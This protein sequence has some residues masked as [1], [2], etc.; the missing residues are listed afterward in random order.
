MAGESP[1]T[2]N[3]TKRPLGAK[4]GIEGALG[5]ASGKEKVIDGY[6]TRWTSSSIPWSSIEVLLDASNSTTQFTKHSLGIKGNS[7]LPQTP[8]DAF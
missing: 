8:E 2:V 6:L 5:A 1:G 3:R 7:S 4:E